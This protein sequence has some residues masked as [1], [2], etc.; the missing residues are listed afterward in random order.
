MLF[1]TAVKNQK[2]QLSLLE[3]TKKASFHAA[4]LSLTKQL[5]IAILIL[6]DLPVPSLF[7]Q[8]LFIFIYYKDISLFVALFSLIAT[9]MSSFVC[10]T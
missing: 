1:F 3:Y 2:S 5:L 4:T 10:E 7:F 9:I 8:F 6:L